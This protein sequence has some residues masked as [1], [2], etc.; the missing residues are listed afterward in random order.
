MIR[1]QRTREKLRMYYQKFM[2][3]GVMDPNVHPWVAEAWQ[4]SRALG[5]PAK[6]FGPF[7][8]LTETERGERLSTARTVI[9]HLDGLYENIREFLSHN[10]ISVLLLDRETY[11][12]KSYTM[13]FYQRT[14][15]ELEGAR[16]ADKDIGASSIGIALTHRTPFVLFGPEIWVE[17]CHDSDAATAPIL[18][19]GEIRYLLSM[20]VMEGTEGQTLSM[21]ALMALLLSLKY[22]LEQNLVLEEIIDEREEILDKVPLI[23]YQVAPDGE[24]VYANRPGSD[25]ILR[26]MKRSHSMEHRLD[27]D[28]TVLNYRHTQIPR[29]FLGIPSYNREFVWIIGN[30]TYE[31]IASIWPNYRGGEVSSATVISTPIEDMKTLLAY[32]SQYK[33]RYSLSS[34]VGEAPRFAA[35]KDKAARCA[36]HLDHLLILGEPG[37]GKQRLAHG[38]HQAGP[39]AAGPLITVRC[40]DTPPE[41][42]PQELF[43]KRASGDVY[44]PGKIELAR[45]GTLFIDEIDKMPLSMG[46][47]LAAA[48]KGAKEVRVIAAADVDPKR[49]VAK[50]LFFE[51]LYFLIAQAV[52][53]TPSLRHRQSD[54]PLIAADI[55]KELSEQHPMEAKQLSAGAISLLTN[56]DWP[57]NVK[58]LQ[59]VLEQGFFLAHGAVIQPSELVLPGGSGWGKAWK[60]DRSVFV[61]AW[62]ACGGNISRLAANLEVSR[63][64]LYRYLEKYGLERNRK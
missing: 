47:E 34:L 44:V 12:L 42:L 15:G 28:E 20:V 52:I 37:T 49:M 57:G 53:R 17:A 33:A 7:V 31:D 26:G 29:A 14:P 18:V 39:H 45:G 22:S 13:S 48:L 27:L 55:L 56:Y 10:N 24:V 51:E 59:G 40:G 25:R 64:T 41:L 30:K 11:V 50:G 6:S 4:K 23:I 5:V 32:A 35:M 9:R 16:L 54:I 58:Q 8:R 61:E 46:S 60:R 1:E 62:K 43:G 21:D 63:V 2:T 36:R 19:G 3:Q 38:I